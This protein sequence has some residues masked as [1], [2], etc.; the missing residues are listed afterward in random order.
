[1]PRPT[2]PIDKL[3]MQKI[4]DEIQPGQFGNTMALCSYVA[5]RYNNEIFPHNSSAQ[6]DHQLVKLRI[7]A[8]VIKLAFP[9]PVGRRGRQKGVSITSEQKEKMQAGRISKSKTISAV[10]DVKKWADNMSSILK[11]R[12][13]QLNG[14][15][16]GNKKTC[17]KT[18]CE[19]CMGGYDRTPEDPA[20]GAAIRDCRG[21]H[22]PLYP[23]RPFQKKASDEKEN[24]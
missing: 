8:G 14:V 24:N 21:F 13:N 18:F 12:P 16:K 2:K 1:M 5:E 9:L 23:I 7:T 10:G 4:V 3:G 15:L 17:V 6:V 11:K 20:L 19:L 22:C